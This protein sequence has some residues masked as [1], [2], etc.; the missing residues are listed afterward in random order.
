M[1]Y[2]TLLN[3]HKVALV[4]K[5]DYKK[6]AEY[7]WYLHDRYAERSDTKNKK[8][9]YMHWDIIGKPLKGMNT[10]HINGDGL[11]N[12]K[13][14]LRHVT[15]RENLL[16]SSFRKQSALYIDGDGL[17]SG[18]SVHFLQ[19][20]NKYQASCYMNGKKKWLGYFNDVV[21]AKQSY[22]NFK[23]SL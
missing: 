23:N 1:R 11:D 10:D 20:R 7:R 9:I 21:S 15:P 16:N 18:L 17:I 3:S 4:D 5:E 13:D 8:H 22:F 19:K 2:I 14:N 6:V 12:R